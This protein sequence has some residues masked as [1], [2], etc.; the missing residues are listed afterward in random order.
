MGTEGMDEVELR[1]VTIHDHAFLWELLK[2]RPQEA[3]ISHKALPPYWKHLWFILSGGRHP[4]FKGHK[5]KKW[6]LIY[7]PVYGAFIRPSQTLGNPYGPIGAIYL[8]NMDEIGIAILPKFQRQGYGKSAIL[9]FQA[10]CPQAS[11]RANIAPGNKASK[12]FFKS[13]GFKKIQETYEC[14]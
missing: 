12:A 7:A 10:K 11:Y 5:Y 13:L 9:A 1:P 14:T 8:T 2:A 3:N 4:K 6:F